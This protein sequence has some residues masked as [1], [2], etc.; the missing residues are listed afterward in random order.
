MI[1]LQVGKT[2]APIIFT[3]S[4]LGNVL[5]PGDTVLGIISSIFLHCKFA[6]VKNYFKEITNYIKKKTLCRSHI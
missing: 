2:D 4:H 6:K 1:L 5:K 3:R